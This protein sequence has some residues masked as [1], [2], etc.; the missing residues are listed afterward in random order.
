MD[1][2]G[3]LRLD[4]WLYFTR[5][6]K[7]RSLAAGA[8]TGGKV[9]VNGERAKAARPVKAGDVIDL[10]RAPYRYRYTVIGVPARRGPAAEANACYVED[11][12]L[13]SEREAN[14]AATRA[15]RLRTPR[16]KG[17]PDKH[18]RR[19]LRQRKTSGDES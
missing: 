16:T 11:E 1:E 17:R 2:S 15:D 19:V 3:Q 8:C 4:K 5:Q 6:F 7:T 14:V 12:A 18:T 13:K 10:T 9:H